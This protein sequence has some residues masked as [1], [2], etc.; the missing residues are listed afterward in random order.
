MKAGLQGKV[1]VVTGGGRGIGRAIALAYGAAGAKVVVG[2]RSQR[3]VQ[4]TADLVV[5]K[6]GQ[7]AAVVADVRDYAAVSAMYVRAEQEFGGVDIVV[8]NAGGAI[9]RRTIEESDPEQ[10]KQTIDVNLTGAL[11]TAHAAIPHLH[12]R[13]GGK[14]F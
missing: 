13:G 5:Q 3:E 2:A 7:A 9:Q 12:R 6:G 8:I 14:R 1:A 10:W 11:Y 4:A